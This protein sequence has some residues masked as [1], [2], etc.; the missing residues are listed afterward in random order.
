[1]VFAPTYEENTDQ[2][3]NSHWHCE[4][5]KIRNSCELMV[6]A[7]SR[8]IW[9]DLNDMNSKGNEK[10]IKGWALFCEK[11]P[12]LTKQLVFFDYGRDVR[13]S[14]EYVKEL[15]IEKSV[16]WMPKMYRKDIMPALF[17]ADMI[18]AEF[19]HSWMTGGVLYEA[20]VASKPILGYRDD[21]LY[22]NLYPSLYPL[23]NANTPETIYCCFE[24]YLAN[25]EVGKKIGLDG[26]QWYE[27]EVVNKAISRYCN[28]INNRAR[29]LGKTPI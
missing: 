22:L 29:E 17:M 12:D 2:I 1:M 28:Y 3:K 21:D 20:L 23:Y 13:K 7:H 4:F 11:Y 15:G 25:P 10:L 26:R 24:E 6:I 14:K 8:H 18:A 27:Q 19:V 9:S 16:T 5:L